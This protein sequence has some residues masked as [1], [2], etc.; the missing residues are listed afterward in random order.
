VWKGGATTEREVTRG[1]AGWAR[2][3]PQD[4][5][6]LIRQLAREFDDAQVARILNRQGRR[7]ARGVAFTASAVRAL[8]S[9]HRIPKCAKTVVTD[10]RHGPFN[11]QQ[12]A[13]E[14]GV[15]MNT[16]HRWLRDGVLAGKQLTS[17]APWRIV[18]TD[19]VR[20][21]LAGG[22]APHGWVGLVEASR[23]LAVSKSQVTYWVKTGKLAAVRVTVGKRR[24]WRI[25]VDSATCG[26]QGGLFDQMSNARSQET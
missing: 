22:D 25:D 17:G 24:C 6:E 19:E 14:L 11:A 7:S 8:R 5:V 18:L 26:P 12:A 20:E 3:T 9:S 21:R 10:P 15:T 4:T 1:A 23:R 2:R 13:R 16:V